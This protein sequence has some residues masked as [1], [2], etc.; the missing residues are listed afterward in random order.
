MEINEKNIE[1]AKRMIKDCKEKPIIIIAQDD[2][3]NRKMLEYGKFDVLLNIENAVSKDSL[4]HIDSGFNHVLARAAAKNKI[5][6]GIDMDYIRTLNN[7]DMSIIFEKIRQ[8]IKICRKSGVK[9]RLLNCKDR[10]DAFALL[11]SIGASS[12]QAKEATESALS[13]NDK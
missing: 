3:F 5:A 7:K 13:G 2:A 9:I 12:K 4:R 11:E 6:I 8:N 1:K 10:K